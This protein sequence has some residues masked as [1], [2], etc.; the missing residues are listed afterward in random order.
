MLAPGKTPKPVLATLNQA[1]TEASKDPELSAKI[2]AQGIEPRDIA[3]ERFDA[4]VRADMA[5]LDPV[6][7]VISEKR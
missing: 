1:M 5:R 3:L 2:R 6:L 4:Y 7:K